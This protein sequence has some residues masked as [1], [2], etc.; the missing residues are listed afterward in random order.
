MKCWKRKPGSA[1]YRKIKAKGRESWQIVLEATP[2]YAESG[3]QV[4]D[5]GVLLSKGESIRVLDTKKENDLIIQF[6]DELPSDPGAP[7][8]ARVDAAQRKR[9]E[10]H[11][12]ATHLLHAALRKTLGDHVAQKGSLVDDA[13]VAVRL[14]AFC[15]NDGRGN[16]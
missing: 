16:C 15:K 2:F 12:S 1:K 6:T 4:G 10:V 11:H 8:I 7:V 9:T 3:G 14:F 5:T 13:A